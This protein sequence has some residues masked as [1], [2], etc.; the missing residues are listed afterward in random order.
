MG[1]G[2]F[3][4]QG[5]DDIPEGGAAFLIH[6]TVGPLD[7][8]DVAPKREAGQDL[9][10][11]QNYIRASP[12]LSEVVLAMRRKSLLAS[13]PIILSTKCYTRPP[14]ILGRRK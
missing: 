13:L 8:L 7:N 11:S 6:I 4:Q 5:H 12:N 10:R 14:F 1:I 3:V 2:G 9:F